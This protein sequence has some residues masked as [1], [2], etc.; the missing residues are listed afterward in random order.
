MPIHARV[1]KDDSV[2]RIDRVIDYFGDSDPRRPGLA[3]HPVS[4]RHTVYVTLPRVSR[5]LRPAPA[6]V[7]GSRDWPPLGS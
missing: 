7:I 3:Q 1:F 6:K 5:M 2:R 4:Q